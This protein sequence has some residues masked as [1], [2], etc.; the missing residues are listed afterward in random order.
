MNIAQPTRAAPPH[1]LTLVSIAAIGPLAMNIFL[2]SLP[3]MARYFQTDYWVIQLLVSLYLAAIAVTQLLIGPL[4]DRYGRRP[5]LLVSLLIF[6]VSTLA[7]IFS[8]NVETLLVCR[9]FQATAA[10]G[11]VLSRAVVR[12][13]VANID[14]AASRIGYVT[15][16]M[17]VMP[18]IA[19]I[20][21]GFLEEHYGWKS[22]FLLTLAITAVVI[23]ITYFNLGE[24]NL[25]RSTSMMGQ[26]RTYPE[27]IRSRRFWGYAMTAGFASGAF[28]AFLGGAPYVATEMLGLGPSDY[29]I[30]FAVVSVGYMAGNY[31]S[32]RFSRSMGVNRMLL[33]GNIVAAAAALISICLFSAGYMHPLSLFAP[34]ALIA[35]G[36][37]M[38][39][40]NSNA[41]MVSVRPH[42]AGSASGLG[43]TMQIGL[44]AV[45]AF[46]AGALL[47]P[48]S[49]PQPLLWV[50][51]SSLLLGVLSTLYVI[52][53]AR[54]V[55]KQD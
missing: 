42:L 34:T 31:M 26:L 6:A 30:Y 22:T 38:V 40:P 18:M 53:V 2:P 20:F 24:T 3:G 50:M 12:D 47:T 44:G 54:Q 17:S 1:I 51:L 10:A 43:G 46:V 33:A 11:M 48:Q 4:S 37:G 5:V 19:P 35:V 36:N 15:M 27:L 16:G 8:P 32:G 23:L 41:G 9:L 28:F 25:N 55:R 52:H 13:T 21:G 29:G 7:A 14:D 39:L 45:L 49:G